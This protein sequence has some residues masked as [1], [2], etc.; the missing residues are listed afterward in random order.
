MDLEGTAPPSFP[1]DPETDLLRS[2]KRITSPISLNAIKHYILDRSATVQ[3]PSVWSHIRSLG[4]E[5]F[6]L[7][8]I[9]GIVSFVSMRQAPPVTPIGITQSVKEQSYLPINSNI[10]STDTPQP[11]RIFSKPPSTVS[12]VRVSNSSDPSI[13]S[14]D[15][16]PIELTPFIINNP[17]PV[18]LQSSGDHLFQYGLRPP[19][20]SSAATG[21][22]ASV[23]GGASFGRMRMLTEGITVGATRGWQL[24]ALQYTATTGHR[25]NL[26]LLEPHL[27]GDPLL[28]SEDRRQ[29]SVLI[30]ATA[31]WNNFQGDVCLGPSYILSTSSLYNTA[32]HSST[33]PIAENGF[34]STAQISI[35]YQLSNFLSAGI[36][37]FANFHPRWSGNG[38]SNTTG[39]LLTISVQP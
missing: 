28:L 10:I 4:V 5:L 18:R 29:I 14:D 6:S 35:K 11:S 37:G 15:S 7:G 21:W 38:E 19:P 31:N 9:V 12:A 34:G 26:E 30:G 22:F 36:L 33:G 17:S 20:E 39:L 3:T 16:A 2:L 8:A 24:A 25:N 23:A 32:S 27:D 13:V 1:G